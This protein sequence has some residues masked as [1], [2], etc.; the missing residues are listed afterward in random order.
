MIA[1]R[2]AASTRPAPID[3]RRRP[4][5]VRQP[6]AEH[7]GDDDHRREGGEDLGAV[8]DVAVVQV[9]DQE[10]RHGGEADRAEREP[11][12][13]E[14]R[15]A[16]DQVVAP[17]RLRLARSERLRDPQRDQGA[18]ERRRQRERPDHLEARGAQD[19]LADRRPQR[20]PAPDR[21]PV[22]ADD[23]AAPLRRREVD[24][25][26][27]AGGVDH[28]LAGAQEEP[29]DDQARHARRARSRARW[30]SRSGARPTITTRR[31]PRR[32]ARCPAS[33]RQARPGDRERAG[34][35]PDRD[36]ARADRALDV[37]RDD[38]QRRPDREQAE[39]GDDEDP[40]EGRASRAKGHSERSA[41]SAAPRA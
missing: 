8:A 25:P 2:P 29:R 12:P 14:Q 26:G 40:G 39:A 16:G 15:L 7:A 34:D 1:T 4:E 11:E 38:R 41:P 21:E 27:R 30:R 24:D 36:V 19:Q 10:R 17:E 6:A 13:G 18:Q 28:A 9:Q 20:Q 32:S 33:G 3:A 31:R 22:E 5:A 35:D 23:P 37:A